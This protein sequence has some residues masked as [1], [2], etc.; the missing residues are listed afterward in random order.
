MAVMTTA[1]PHEASAV[2]R[3]RIG[4]NAYIEHDA[5]HVEFSPSELGCANDTFCDCGLING[6]NCRIH[7]TGNVSFNGTTCVELGDGVTFNLNGYTL[8]CTTSDCGYGVH[9]SASSGAADKVVIKN[10]KITGCWDAGVYVNGGTN[11]SVQDLEVDLGASCTNGLTHN[12]GAA[13]V[14]IFAPRGLTSHVKVYHTN[15]G[16]WMSPGQDIED[17]VLKDN[18]HGMLPAATGAIDNVLFQD[19]SSA[20]IWEYKG[21][22]DPDI[23]GSVFTGTGCNCS[24]TPSGVSTSETCQ[25]GGLRDCG[26]FQAPPSIV[27]DPPDDGTATSCSIEE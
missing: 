20:H 4:T 5:S 14:G 7:L 18:V 3:C 15:I 1:T 16:F 2:D 10:G 23:S 9:N 6:D 19:N 12:G 22:F 11:S 8:D 27:C 24:T 17:S 21:T 25:S 26:T 13:T